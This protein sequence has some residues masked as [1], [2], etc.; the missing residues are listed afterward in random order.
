MTDRPLAALRCDL[1]TGYWRRGA[2][3]VSPDAPYTWASG[4]KM[5]VYT[6]TRSL[7]GD[8]NLRTTI[9]RGL[10]ALVTDVCAESIAWI[11]GTATAGIP[12]ATSLADRMGLPLGYVRAVAKTHGAGRS[13]EGLSRDDVQR[14]GGILVEDLISTG[15]SVLHAVDAL[16]RHG[17]HV[18]LIVAIFSYGLPIAAQ[19]LT[20]ARPPVR[21]T[22]LCSLDDVVAAG[23]R[24]GTLSDDAAGV[25]AE[26][27]LDPMSWWERHAMGARP[28]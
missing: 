13:V 26:W 19:R 28:S 1:A 27:R 14:G 6:D 5:P 16:R 12:H 22:V 7:L 15:G 2:F 8:P 17:A 10:H 25:V 4:K 18:E 21:A 20:A 11:A 23:R 9:A 24:L 3:H